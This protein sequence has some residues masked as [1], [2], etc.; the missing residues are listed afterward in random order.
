MEI[1]IPELALVVMIG[2][3]G[4][5]KSTFARQHFLRTEII[6]ATTVVAW[7]R[8][9]RTIKPPPRMRLRFCSSSLPNASRPAG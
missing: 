1:R 3:S 9:T 5:G 7:S 4:S 6:P 8:T 2:T